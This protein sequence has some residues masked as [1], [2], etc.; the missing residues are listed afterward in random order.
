MNKRNE[1]ASAFPAGS[2]S[3]NDRTYTSIFDL[4]G[5]PQFSQ[6]LPLA[7]Q[8]VV[9]MI[10]GC[11]TPAIIVS[12]AAGLTDSQK[13]VLIQASLVFA[14]LS[15][16]LML[17]PLT[18]GSFQLGAKLPM[19]M[20]VSFAYVPTLTAIAGTGGL[21]V[22]FGA[23]IIGA[24]AAFAIG[25]CITKIRKLFPPLVTGTV[26]FTIGLSLY[27]TAV[28]YIAGGVGQTTYG[29]AKNWIVG[30]FT[31]AVVTALNHYGKGFF[32]LASILVG[33]FCGYLLALV[34]DMVSFTSVGT[35][36]WFAAP[37]FMYFG[38]RFDPASCVALGILFIINSVQAIGD[39]SATTTGAMDREPTDT[40]LK[41]AITAY[42]V[43]NLIGA[44]FG[45]L[46]TASYSQNVGIVTT[47][48]V[49]SRAVLGLA[50]VIILI[51]GFL[52]KFSALL[53]TIPYC[54]LGGATISVFA[55][56][57]MTGLK[58]VMRDNMGFRNTSILGLSAALGVGITQASASLEQ[59]PSWVM[60][61]FGKSP[62]VVAAIVAILMNLLLPKEK[63][64][65]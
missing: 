36:G 23:Q 11:I 4:D 29:S 52:P 22:V 2:S 18:I 57:A 26:V 53:T 59:F 49:I 33:M 64:K 63:Q 58:L 21:A 14:A 17:F 13:V 3:R 46:P 8:H 54:V 41:G 28:N 1:G 19:I 12:G 6:A 38:I 39:F 48:K 25:L 7:M 51:A 34:L 31:L 37:R 30:L 9:A 15:T 45:C 50:A 40:E 32:K 65:E 61:I 27:P 24:V 16:L 43:T 56:I 60:T 20:G 35:A 42:G 47:N 44:F 62:V 55:S 10:V 5:V